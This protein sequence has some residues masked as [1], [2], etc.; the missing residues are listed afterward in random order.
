MAITLKSK[1]GVLPADL[2]SIFLN[3][4]LSDVQF[5]VTHEDEVRVLR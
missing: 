2:N 4:D 3:K 5:V 1:H